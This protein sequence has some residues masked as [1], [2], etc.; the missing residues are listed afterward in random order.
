[1]ASPAFRGVINV[2]IR[3]STPDWA[4]FEPPRAPDGALN[5][6][7]ILLDTVRF[8]AVSCYGG[9]IPTPNIG[10]IA[11]DGVRFTQWRTT[12]LCSPTRS[13][14]RT[15]HNHTRKSMAYITEAASGFPNASGTIHPRTL[16]TE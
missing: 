4:P 9:P 10:R 13:C 2:D 14:L 16:C 7:H 8:S 5:V 15:G 11:A 3:D 6:V 12:A 1:M